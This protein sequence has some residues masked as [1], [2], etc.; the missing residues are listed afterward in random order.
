MNVRVIRRTLYAINSFKKSLKIPR[1]SLVAVNRTSTD[2]AMVKRRSTDTA[3]VKRRSTDNAMVKRRSTDNA[4]VKRRSADNTMV[5]REGQTIQWSKG[6]S[7]IN[8]TLHKK[9]IRL[10]MSGFK[11]I[12]CRI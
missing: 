2:N 4:M 10:Q 1:G 8:K 7:M 5:K 9:L 12:I 3:M 6:K 11:F